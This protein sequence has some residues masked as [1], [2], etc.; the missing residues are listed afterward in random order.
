MNNPNLQVGVLNNVDDN[1][2]TIT[3]PTNYN[4]M[5]VVATVNYSSN[6]LPII[7]RI[8][9]AQDNSFQIKLQSP[10]N[11]T[12]SD[13]G[14]YSVNYIVVEEGVY[15]QE[16][17]GIEMEAVEINSTTTDYKGNW[18]GE[19]QTYQNSYENPVVI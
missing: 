8:R 11:E 10:S 12:V 9:N 19:V 2:Q 6:N 4:S 5:V 7:A 15:T 16:E 3:L 18:G 17:H 1:W 13:F 14:D